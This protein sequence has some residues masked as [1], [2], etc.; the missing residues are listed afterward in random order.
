MNAQ[1]HHH[2]ARFIWDLCNLL[3]GPY[4]RNEYRKVILPLTVLRRFDC[5]LAPTKQKVLDA[6]I[7]HQSKTGN[8]RRKLLEAAAGRPFYNTSEFDFPLLL[9]DPNNLTQ[10]LIG[11]QLRHIPNRPQTAYNSETSQHTQG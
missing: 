2:L 9:N 5:V 11:Y 4:K 10:N 1:T 3:R 8:V 7:E 6:D